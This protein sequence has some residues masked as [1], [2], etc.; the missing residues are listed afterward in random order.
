MRTPND[1]IIN[2]F[3][4][5]AETER[6]TWQ[7]AEML[8]A[9]AAAVKA[10]TPIIKDLAEKLQPLFK[11]IGD[12]ID[13]IINLYPNKRVIYLAKHGKGR[14]KKKNINRITAWAKKQGK[15]PSAKRSSRGYIKYIER[16]GHKYAVFAQSWPV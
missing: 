9:F 11:T 8:A 3:G 5:A 15:T 7:A 13:K 6:Q 12:V 14:T 16:D 1:E 4:S 2:L 10:L